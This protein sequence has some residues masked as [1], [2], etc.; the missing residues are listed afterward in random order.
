M[1]YK[2]KWYIWFSIFA[3]MFLWADTSRRI[4]FTKKNYEIWSRACGQLFKLFGGYVILPIMLVSILVGFPLSR[5]DIYEGSLLN[6]L[7]N[8]LNLILVYLGGV[9]ATYRHD[10][11]RKENISHLFKNYKPPDN[12]TPPENPIA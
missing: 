4:M 8:M 2:K 10:I 12:E 1:K 7:F 9:Y 5:L 11:W 3:F 6:E